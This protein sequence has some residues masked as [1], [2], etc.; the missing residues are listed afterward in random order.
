MQDFEHHAWPSLQPAKKRGGDGTRFRFRRGW[1]AVAILFAVA[2]MSTGGFL[3]YQNTLPTSLALNVS[4][5]AKEVPN[6]LQL[7]LSFSRSVT[8]D[9]VATHLAVTPAT[10]AKLVTDNGQSTYEWMPAKPLADL[11]TYTVVVSPFTDGNKHQFRGGRWTFTTTIVPRIEALNLPDGSAVTDGL[12][13]QPGS[14]LTFVFNDVMNPDTVKISFNTQPATITWSKD[15]RSASMATSAI[16]SGPLVLQLGAGAK[17]SAGRVVRDR[18]SIDTGL[19][20]RDREHTIALKFPALI[21]VPNDEA[22]VDQDGLQAADMVFEYLAEGGITRLTAVFD[23]APDL[24]GPMRS[25]RLVSLKIA[26]HYKGLLFQSGESPVT[27][28]AAGADPVPQFFDTIGYMFRTGSRY[29]PDNLMISGTNVNRAEQRF[30][31]LGAFT[32]AK[33]RPALSG[34]GAAS[35]VTVSEH[36]SVYTY[37][38]M[39]G[40]YQKSELSHGYRDAHTGQPLRIEMLIVMHTQ[41]SLL[42]VGDGHGSYIHDFNLD[43]SGR[44][45]IYYKGQL[46]A[47]SWASTDR[48][49][50]IAFSINGQPVALPPGLVWVDLTT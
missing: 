36:Y 47:A 32:L 7:K 16:P 4:N 24:I 29:A 25:S 33:A 28:A 31:S 43:T 5:G 30:P 39:F 9:L 14:R 26:R 34:G 19:Y 20:Y 22:A 40:T 2:C 48:N 42:P 3:A 12:E 17:D 10:D 21:Q 23:N 11:T 1:V 50:P 37:D 18:W 45:D 13:V 49:G 6:D 15:M 41:E 46:Y 35:R 27:R 8:P 38:P 44:A